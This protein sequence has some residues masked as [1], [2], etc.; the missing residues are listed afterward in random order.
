MS[1]FLYILYIYIYESTTNWPCSIAM[2]NYQRNPEG[3]STSQR[4]FGY[5]L[6]RPPMEKRKNTC[7]HGGSH[8]LLLRNLVR[9]PLGYGD[10]AVTRT[11][12]PVNPQGRFP[13]RMGSLKATTEWI[14]IGHFVVRVP[15]TEVQGPLQLWQ[16]MTF[17]R[18]NTWAHG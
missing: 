11:L 18:E 16:A 7:V 4:M 15:C 13:C 14:F 9:L 12:C 5:V 2:L 8:H 6:K 17:C 3:N 10:R 1:I